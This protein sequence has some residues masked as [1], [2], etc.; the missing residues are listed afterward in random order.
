MIRNVLNRTGKTIKKF[1]DFYFLSYHRKLGWFFQKND[2]K[3]TITWKIKI[4]KIWKLVL[5]SIE[6]N[7]AEKKIASFF[8][9]YVSS[10]AVGLRNLVSKVCAQQHSRIACHIVFRH[11]IFY[12]FFICMITIMDFFQN[13]NFFFSTFFIFWWKIGN[14]LNRK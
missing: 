5:L 14:R 1:S 3:M 7:E 8:C 11:R 10:L 6:K 12:F 2:T 9:S 13:P 4:G